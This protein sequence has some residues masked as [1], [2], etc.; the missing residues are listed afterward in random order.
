[1]ST[2]DHTSYEIGLG[3]AVQERPV[4]ANCARQS[5]VARIRNEFL[6]IAR[7]SMSAGTEADAPAAVM[8]VALK[9]PIL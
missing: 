7:Q 2:A 4:P 9:P 5:Y 1:M 8:R 3:L 6:V